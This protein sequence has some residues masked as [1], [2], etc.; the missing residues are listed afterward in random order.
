M[1]CTRIAPTP[2]GFLHIGNAANFV[3]AW[4]WARLN[5]GKIIL[6]IDDLDNERFRLEYLSDIF[7]TLDWL[8]I[9]WDEGATS[10]DDFLKNHSQH[11]RLTTYQKYVDL[12]IENRLLYA[13]DCSRSRI[14]ANFPNGIYRGTCRNKKIE[15]KNETT[16]RITEGGTEGVAFR[17]QID[18]NEIITFKEKKT[19]HQ[20]DRQKIAVAELMG[21]VVIR[22][23]NGFPAYQIASLIDDIM[24]NVN[25]IVRGKDLLGSTAAQIYLSQQLQKTAATL[26]FTQFSDTY[27]WHH[28]LLSNA[29][30]E[31]LSKSKGA[32][33]LR[34]WRENGQSPTPIFKIVANWFG[35]N[36]NN[37]LTINE[38]LEAIKNNLNISQLF[39]KL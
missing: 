6:R 12:L 27:F 21:D 29:Q 23:K 17:L 3:A 39:I 8:G 9:T 16:K 14:K 31:K 28:P 24:M 38:L 22:Q 19:F 4:V 30:G 36:E 2:S 13:C 25:F 26:P 5:D 35:V 34:T 33:S 1:L 32:A 37:I 7:E 10:S 20:F 18:E 15:A 11:S